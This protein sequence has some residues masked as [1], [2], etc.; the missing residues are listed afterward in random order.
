MLLPVPF[1]VV[2]C[3]EQSF[4]AST[5]VDHRRSRALAELQEEVTEMHKA[6]GPR[7]AHRSRPKSESSA[8]ETV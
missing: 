1:S 5:G 3:Q 8:K 2:S 6:G 7:R 4:R